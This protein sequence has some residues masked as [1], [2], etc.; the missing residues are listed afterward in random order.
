M[1]QAEVVVLHINSIPSALVYY[2]NVHM[3]VLGTQDY[4]G[5]G[6]QATSLYGIKV[7]E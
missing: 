4:H 2:Q 3:Y 5:S 6:K 1:H 7:N